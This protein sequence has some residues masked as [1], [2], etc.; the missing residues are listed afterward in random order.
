MIYKLLFKYMF[1]LF[2][3]TNISLYSVDFVLFTEPKTGTNLLTAILKELTGKNDYWPIEY[4]NNVVPIR[5]IAGKDFKNPK[6]IFFSITPNPWTKQVMDLVWKTN[7]KQGTFLHLHPPY[8]P[9]LEQYL[10]DKNV[11]NFFIKRDPRDRIVSLLNHFKHIK[12]YDKSVEAI[13]SDEEKLLFMIKNRLKV[14]TVHY[15]GWLKSPVCCVLDFCKLMGAHGGVATDEDALD[16]MRKIAQA[17]KINVSDD[18]LKDVYR[19]SFGNG[20][21]FFKGKV[22][23]WKDYFNEEH[24]AAVKS[25]IGALLIEL[26]YEKDYD[27]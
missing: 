26:G 20:W 3:F 12:A 14:Q 2:V 5:K 1:L 19:K 22:G 17:L 4:M 13:P 16:Q 25:E 9:T 8:S 27:W 23:S 15:M 11:I 10:V 18:Y 24:K 21:S 7:K 6:Y